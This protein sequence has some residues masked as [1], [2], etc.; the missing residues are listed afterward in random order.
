M[1]VN[2]FPLLPGAMKVIG[3]SSKKNLSQRIETG[4]VLNDGSFNEEF[5]ELWQHL[6]NSFGA[7][8]VR[9]AAALQ[10]RYCEQP[11][12]QYTMLRGYRGDE[13]AGYI[14]LR[15]CPPNSLRSL[16]KYPMPKYPIGLI[17]DYLVDPQD[18]PLF[19]AMLDKATT[20]LLK[21]GARYLLC[22]STV[23]A[24]HSILVRRGFLHSGT[25]LVGSK[26]SVLRVGFTFTTQL[27]V[28]ALNNSPWFL[29]LSDCDTDLLWGSY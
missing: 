18:M 21:H 29:T 4:P 25:P 20:C 15:T 14:I 26:L 17:V 22:L 28:E 24:F 16:R 13:L 9:D 1:Y 23:P 7:I 27:N 3:I 10:R 8:A 5:D 11:D 19:A 6:R 12:R 2:L